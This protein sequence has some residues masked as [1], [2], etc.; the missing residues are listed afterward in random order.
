MDMVHNCPSAAIYFI[1]RILQSQPRSDG[2]FRFIAYAIEHHFNKVSQMPV[3]SLYPNA[4]PVVR[5]TK[6]QS[7]QKGYILY[8][9]TQRLTEGPRMFTV[10]VQP[11]SLSS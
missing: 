2:K 7:S 8:L 1:C 4:Q 5:E 10:S 6:H 9:N 3:G 11:L